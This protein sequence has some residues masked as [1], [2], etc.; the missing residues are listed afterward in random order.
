MR[1]PSDR[2]DEENGSPDARFDERFDRLSK[3]LMYASGNFQDDSDYQAI[4]AMKKVVL[5]ML[6]KKLRNKE[7][8]TWVIVSIL[9]TITK[10][11]PVRSWNRGMVDGVREAWLAWADKHGYGNA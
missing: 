10:S 8:P 4:V 3:R 7:G 2:C 6:F 1:L 9:K 11:N 5:P